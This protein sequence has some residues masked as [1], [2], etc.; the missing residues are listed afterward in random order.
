MVAGKIKRFMEENGI[1]QAWL[2]RKLEIPPATMN[3]I[4]NGNQ[5]LKADMFIQ[6][7]KLLRVSPEEIGG[8]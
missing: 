5:Q 4:L 2:A 1:S 6:I 3:G 7:C 8:D